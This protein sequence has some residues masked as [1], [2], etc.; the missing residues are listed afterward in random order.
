M[1]STCDELFERLL[2]LDRSGQAPW[3]P[4]HGI[5]TACFLLQHPAHPLAARGGNKGAWARLYFYVSGGPS[6]FLAV[7]EGARPRNSHRHADAPRPMF[8]PADPLPEG[9]APTC[10][11]TTIVD[12]A[13]DGSF[14]AEGYEQRVSAWALATRAAW[15]G[16]TG[17]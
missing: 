5:V 6:G 12:V 1:P 15:T 2:E 3:E 10:F 9:P 14:P 4:L 11:D 13:V 7:I 16:D 17:R 8:L